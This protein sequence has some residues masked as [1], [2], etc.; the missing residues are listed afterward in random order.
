M[1]TR[2]VIRYEILVEYHKAYGFLPLELID[3][4]TDFCYNK[5]YTVELALK[6]VKAINSSKKRLIL[7][8][9][10]SNKHFYNGEL[11]TFKGPHIRKDVKETLNKR[12]EK[13]DC[14][15]MTF[16]YADNKIVDL[17]IN[18]TRHNHRYALIRRIK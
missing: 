17:T 16:I 4:K 5:D 10:Y 12:L 7:A 11:E 13:S 15:H 3:R 14:A 2:K 9:G 18:K 6:I 1:N 8:S